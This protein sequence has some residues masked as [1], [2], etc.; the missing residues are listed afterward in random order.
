MKEIT[1]DPMM[2]FYLNGHYNIKNSP[3]E[4]YARELQE[5]FTLGKGANMWTEDDV[6]AAAK[7]ITGFRADTV[8]LTYTFDPAKHETA[9]KTFL[10]TIIII[11]S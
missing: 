4:N 1:K 2:L 5:L 3:D 9:N 6:K 11:Q 10:H 8:N 7:V